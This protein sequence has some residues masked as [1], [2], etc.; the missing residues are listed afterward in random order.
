[1]K[2]QTIHVAQV[3]SVVNP[4]MNRFW[5]AYKMT[6]KPIKLEIRYFLH[7]ISQVQGPDILVKES[8]LIFSIIYCT[9]LSIIFWDGKFLT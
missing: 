6:Q 2:V 3:N 1:M 4:T 7:T 5:D 9:F 8:E